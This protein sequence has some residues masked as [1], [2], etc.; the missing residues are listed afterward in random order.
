MRLKILQIV[1]VPDWA[2]NRLAAPVVEYNDH[3]DWQV[4]FLHPKELEQGRIDLEPVRKAI[5]WCDVIDANYWRSLAQLA[6]LIPQLKK[7]RVVLTHHNEKNLLDADWSYVHTFVCTTNYIEDTLKENYPNAKFVKIHNAYDWT[8]KYQEKLDPPKPAIGYVGRVVE[9]KGL[10]EIA[11]VAYELGFP[12]MF[13]GKIDKPNYFAQIPQEHRDN[14]DFTYMEC[15]DDERREYFKQI[16]CYIGFSGGGRETGPLGL[17]EAMACG[18]PVI[19][20]NAGIAADICQDDVNALIVDY[21]DYDGLK[22]AT[23]RM[24][25]SAQLRERLRADAWDTIRNFTDY[26]RS[27]LYRNMFN[28]LVKEITGQELVSIITPYTNERIPQIEKILTS[29]NQQTY[30]NFELILIADEETPSFPDHTSV[31]YPVKIFRTGKRD[32]YNLALARNLGV[33]ESD[34]KYLMFCDSRLLPE[35]DAIEV[36]VNELKSKNP[37]K[38]WVFGSKGY[39]K[40]HFVENFSMIERQSLVMGGMFN[41]RIDGYG[42]MSQELRERFLHQGFDLRFTPNAKSTEMLRARKDQ[43]RREEIIKMKALLFK[44]H[45]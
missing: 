35:P 7:K 31:K 4:H 45:G 3:F 23:Q 15:D 22:E 27:L 30:K 38:S 40:T 19:T 28:D 20:T 43:K 29:L 14:I 12:L 18:V 1:D 44:L 34:G 6:E 39:E 37:S 36:F 26:R 5:E 21:D 2:I 33:I 25:D 42:G 32:G 9:W 8:M 13:M 16:T 41:E 24:M 11:R 10:K 17:M